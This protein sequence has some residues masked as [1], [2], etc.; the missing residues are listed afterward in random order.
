MF[1]RIVLYFCY[2]AIHHCLLFYI[3]FNT[4]K[5]IC[6]NKYRSE[7]ETRINHQTQIHN[8]SDASVQ[9]P[10]PLRFDNWIYVKGGKEENGNYR[11]NTQI[12]ARWW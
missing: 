5:A 9:F 3:Y 12:G 11:K 6:R 10:I 8:A 4:L 7:D 1:P 2:H